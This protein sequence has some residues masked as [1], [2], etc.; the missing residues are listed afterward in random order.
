MKPRISRLL[1]GLAL[2]A[3]AP[4]Y[5]EPQPGS[6]RLDS[7]CG[8]LTK[9]IAAHDGLAETGPA[10][11]GWFCDFAQTGGKLD[12]EWYVVALRSNRTCEGICSNLM[13]WYAVHR[14]SGEVHEFDVNEFVVGSRISAPTGTAP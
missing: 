4:A 5:A 10:G 13:G 3:S 8:Q 7:A 9:V 14:E 1:L 2:F 11:M 6:S 12:D